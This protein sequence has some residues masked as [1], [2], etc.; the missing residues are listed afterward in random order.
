MIDGFIEIYYAPRARRPRLWVIAGLLLCMTALYLLAKPRTAQAAQAP[1]AQAP[2]TAKAA[3]AAPVLWTGDGHWYLFRFA[4]D[5]GIETDIGR[6]VRHYRYLVWPYYVAENNAMAI[7]RMKGR[8]KVEKVYTRDPKERLIFRSIPGWYGMAGYIR[9]D[10]EL[11]EPDPRTAGLSLGLY[12]EEG[13]I[14]SA[15]ACEELR[16]MLEV[17]QTVGE[18][19][20]V[21]GVVT[22]W[23]SLEISYVLDEIPGL[24]YHLEWVILRSENKW[25]LVPLEVKTGA[26]DEYYMFDL[27]PESPLCRE[28]TAAVQFIEEY[29]THFDGLI[30]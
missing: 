29:G 19:T 11:P 10:L 8:D 18:P 2:K 9:D 16:A 27:D 13:V 17:A 21:S 20:D 1:T 15:A 30:Y 3:S 12:N 23:Q 7:G 5:G 22:H 28:Y 24:R 14:L 4:N 25:I 6:E 26:E